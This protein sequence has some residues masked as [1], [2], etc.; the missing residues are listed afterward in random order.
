MYKLKLLQKQRVD[1]SVLP[2]FRAAGPQLSP[3]QC[4]FGRKTVPFL[5]MKF[6]GIT[7]KS[8]SPNPKKVGA[9]AENPVPSIMPNGYLHFQESLV[10]F[11]IITI[12]R[13]G[14]I[15]API[16]I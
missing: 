2:K 15:V 12:K 14:I 1:I 16:I 10:A 5:D 11:A 13:C 8:T 9:I 4:H 6:L 3:R 7:F